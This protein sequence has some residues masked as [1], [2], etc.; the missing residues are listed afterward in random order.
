M[1]R[2]AAELPVNHSEISK[3]SFQLR[4]D[5][6]K[7]GWLLILAATSL[8]IAIQ[9][10]DGLYNPWAFVALTVSLLSALAIFLTP[11]CPPLEKLGSRPFPWL[12]G[13]GIAL[14]FLQLFTYDHPG[15]WHGPIATL[16]FKAWLAVAAL[17]ALFMILLPR[18]R[19]LFLLI[20]I[21]AFCVN[22]AW[23]IRQVPQPY[24]DVWML[25][26]EGV[27]AFVH[28]HNPF[29]TPFP[30]IYHRPELYGPGALHSDGLIHQGFPYPPVVF[31]MDYL[32]YLIGGDYRWMN[33]AAMALGALL[34]GLTNF[35]FGRVRT[36]DRFFGRGRQMV[37]SADPTEKTSSGCPNCLP[38]LAAL[39]F[40]FT[41]RVY[42][43]LES[44][45][46]EPVTALLLIATIFFTARK[47]KLMPVF[48]GMFLCSKQYLIWAIP[49][50]LLLAGRP[51]NFA[52][53]IRLTAIAFLTGCIVSLPLILWNVHAYL[54]ANVSVA[55]DATVRGD[56][57]SYIAL[58]TKT[59]G[60]QPGTSFVTLIGCGLAVAATIL[61]CLRGSRTPAGYA[62]AVATAHMVFFS[63]YK[64]AFCNYNWFLIAA[65][66]TALAVLQPS[67]HFER[68]SDLAP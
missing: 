43:V 56:A 54:S 5:A 41:P 28:G 29:A 21:A 11:A 23:I 50:L 39:L 55:Q 52:R 3:P 15:S 4:T 16:H 34:I 8:G 60:W 18:G 6:W 47:S 67:N 22:G 31:W 32:G 48:L 57:L 1:Q 20:A 61:V 38:T 40:L 13:A 62:A 26:T 27:K 53:L 42:F 35:D 66:C 59:T 7:D 64:F 12:I 30:D 51:T 2:N 65:F 49:P 45:W 37:R 46:T 10:R 24:M 68:Q 14:N 17:A 25:Q 58:L 63:F 44:G 9:I 33:L 19:H 36:A